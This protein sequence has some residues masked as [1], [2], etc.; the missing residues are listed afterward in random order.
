MESAE[1]NIAE[2]QAELKELSGDLDE[3]TKQVEQVKKTTSK[4]AK[5]L[6]QALKEIATKV[7]P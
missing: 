7:R 3:K 5:I 6:D 2:L 4:S 1:E